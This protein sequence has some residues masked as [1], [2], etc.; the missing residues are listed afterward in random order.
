MGIRKDIIE[1]NKELPILKRYEL[2]DKIRQLQTNN[3][4]RDQALVCFLYLTGCRIEEVVRFIKEK[5]PNRQVVQKTNE[6]GMVRSY[7]VNKPILERT[8]EGHPIRKKQ[9]EIH[10]DTIMVYGVRSLKRKKSLLRNIPIIRNDRESWFI[11]TFLTHLNRL[12]DDD[13]LF[14]ITRIRAYQ[15]LKEIGLFCHYLRH[16]RL[17]HLAMDYDFNNQEIKQF[18]GWTS[19][20][21]AD[22]YVSLNVTHLTD[23][24][25]KY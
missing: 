3:I 7:K 24:M 9:V 23:K 20:R 8:T 14:D 6:N 17:S 19:S 18:T 22:T 12:E 2:I 5:N 15:I 11:D 4:T 16:I 10:Q 1:Q 21:P 13:Y 25:R